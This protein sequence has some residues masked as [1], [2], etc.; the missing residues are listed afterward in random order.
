MPD[1]LPRRTVLGGLLLCFFL[2]GA[3]GLIYQVAWGKALGLVFGHTAYALATVLAVFMG[4]LAAGSAWLGRAGDRSAR[5]IALYGWIE[6]GIAVTGAASLLGL[7]GVRAAYLAAY[8]SVAAHGSLLLI[9][10]IFGSALVLFLPTFLMG[11]TL[12]ILVRGLTR[13]SSE[14]GTEF[15]RLY[16]VNT[17]GAV[18]GTLAAG[19]VILPTLG[20][21]T[22]IG[23]AVAINLIAGVFALSL[24]RKVPVST[25]ISAQP[26]PEPTPESQP[27]SE[28]ASS[29]FLLVSFAIVGATAMA[30]EIGWARLLATQLGSSTYAF[31]LMLATFLIG[32]VL[33]SAL[34]GVWSRRYRVNYSTFALT[35]TLTA[36]AAFSFLIF[37]SR[38]IEILPPILQAAHGSFQGLVTAQ[39]ILCMLAILP[40]ALVFGFNFPAVTMLI[41]GRQM[42]PGSGSAKIVGRAYAWNTFGAIIGALATGFLLLPRLGSFRLLAATAG[43]NLAL[44]ALL[45]V[46]NAPRAMFAFA[47]NLLLLVAVA[48]IGFSN[49][50]Y[51]P[52]VAAFNTVL[53]WNQADRPLPLTLREK[54]RLMDVVYFKEGLNSTITVTQTDDYISLRTNGKVDASNHD[55][56]TQLLLGHLGALARPPRRVLVIGFGG[57]MTLSAVARYPELERLD[58]VEIEPAVLGAAPLLKQLNRGVLEDPRVHIIFDDARNFLFTTQQKYDLI[59]SE[60]SNPWISGVAALYTREFY[61][62][63]QERLAPGGVFVQWVQTYSLFPEDL[64]MVLATFLSEF[65]GATLWHG[66]PPDLLLMSQTPPAAEMLRRTQEM[67][68]NPG[69]RD[70]YKQLGIEQPA[71]LYGFYMLDDAGLRNFSAGARLNTDDLTLLE[72]DAPRSLLVQ[73]LEANNRR[74]IFLS[75]KDVLPADFPSDLRDA[76]VAAAALTSLNAHDMDGADKFARA[77]EKRPLTAEIA[78]VQGRVALAH[79]DFEGASRA[80]DAAL[81]MDPN[82]IEAS[83]GR[84]ETDRRLGNPGK[85]YQGFLHILER[86]PGHLQSLESLKQLAK[87]SS[88]WPEA[89]YFQ[90]KLITSDPHASAGA[91]ADL[92]ELFLRVGDLDLA[93]KAMQDCLSRDPYNF[94]TRINFAELLSRQKKWAEARKNLEFVKRHFPDGDAE[95]YALLYEVDNAMGDPRGAADAVRFGLRIFPENSDLLRLNLLL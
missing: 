55:T 21:R 19:F 12:P 93:Y 45:S 84:A 13:S 10:R 52:A 80:F 66:D 81:T 61:S 50:L 88:H 72:Y 92:A 70:D 48:V 27:S 42:F 44:A 74:D 78:T 40:A 18:A 9:L 29:R 69:L 73:G 86:D 57:G 2:S 54:A 75:R 56:S 24:S 6:M 95:T 11:G 62:A 91:Y 25:T 23:I 38:S 36:V 22:T 32:I 67:F 34:F 51:D 94:Q 37:F 79:S 43:V 85:A 4:G 59:V 14:V 64:R 89:E 33:G 71:G 1:S 8:P 28:E 60:P 5:P 77:L 53:Y 20:L 63:A 49:F 17:A 90:L 76:A 39:F 65:K 82:S 58:C 16:W 46:V 15:A 35:Q 26:T 31:T 83:W 47:G 7:A 87:D 3:A 41:A 30:Y 68:A